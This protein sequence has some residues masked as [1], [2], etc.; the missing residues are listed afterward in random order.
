MKNQIAQLYVI[1]YLELKKQNGNCMKIGKI[2]TEF[3]KNIRM[4]KSLF[5]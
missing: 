5:Q 2:L 3:V 1:H 4:G